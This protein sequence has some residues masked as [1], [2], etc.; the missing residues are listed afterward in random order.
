[1]DAQLTQGRDDRPSGG[2][3]LI[4]LMLVVA[5]L[6]VLSVMAGLSVTRSGV[7]PRSDRQRFLALDRALR[8]EALMTRQTRQMRV[9]DV[10][11]AGG[12][13][14]DDTAAAA[15]D[16]HPWDSSPDWAE[17]AGPERRLTYL[18]DGRSTPLVVD[19]REGT[20]IIRCVGDGWTGPICQDR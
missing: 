9:S 17:P 8:E 11:F 4:E 20:R 5:I 1:M 14:P 6:S 10:G 2:F 3:S 15:G 18:P 16:E 7:D 19:F 13:G 12:P